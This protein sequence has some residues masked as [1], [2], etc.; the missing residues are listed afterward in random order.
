MKQLL[1]LQEQYIATLRRASTKP[2]EL[3]TAAKYAAG[4]YI[5]ECQIEGCTA[6]N[7]CN[8][9]TAWAKVWDDIDA[10]LNNNKP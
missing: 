8:Y 3:L 10:Y 4:N 2:I 7:R 6:D 5:S 1:K 9:C